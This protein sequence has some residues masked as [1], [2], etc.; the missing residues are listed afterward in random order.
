MTKKIIFSA[1]GTGGHIF[2][3]IN[4]MKYL[5]NKGYDVLLVTDVRASP[6]LKNQTTF[7]SCGISAATPSN[8]SFLKKIFSFIIIIFS[9]IRSVII[10]KKENPD[11]IIGFG[12]YVSFPISFSSK[13]YSIP[14]L[15]YENNMTIID[16]KFRNYNIIKHYS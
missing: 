7:R 13:L 3:A 10:L 6:F 14:L 1:G 16:F 5:S 11:L 4:L 15:I 9:I 8:K 12:G 2:P